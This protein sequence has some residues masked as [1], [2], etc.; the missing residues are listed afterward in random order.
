MC[1]WGGG[2]C[3]RHTHALLFLPLFIFIFFFL[4]IGFFYFITTGF[5]FRNH[6]KKARFPVLYIHMGFQCISQLAQE[7]QSGNWA[8][9]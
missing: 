1:A 3:R 2:S 8:G 7:G 9:S 5:S 6:T 4:F